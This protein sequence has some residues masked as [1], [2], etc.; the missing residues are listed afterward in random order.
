M[1]KIILSTVTIVLSIVFISY[2][3]TY[4]FNAP[5]INEY[6]GEVFA[7]N[8]CLNSH[9]STTCIITGTITYDNNLYLHN[10][11][12][13][14]DNTYQIPVKLSHHVIRNTKDITNDSVNV[15]GELRG[16][17]HINNYKPIKHHYNT[18]IAAKYIQK[19]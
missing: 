12:I 16:A 19:Q 2:T 5:Q 14:Q 1:I 3:Q 7:I 9:E 10:R 15:I 11:Y 13:I 17:Y 18:H 8:D 4:A 6:F